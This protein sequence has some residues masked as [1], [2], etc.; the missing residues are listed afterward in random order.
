MSSYLETL[1][2]PS[3][4]V[5]LGRIVS[6]YGVNGLLK[7]YP[8]SED[9][10]IL[11]NISDCWIVSNKCRSITTGLNFY[12]HNIVSARIHG[13]FIIVRLMENLS[14]E[15]S[16]ALRGY[17]ICVS[18]SL[19]PS[20]GDDE[21]Y[22]VDLIGCFVHGYSGETQCCIGVVNNIFENGA[23]P[24]LSITPDI[25][26]LKNYKNKNKIEDILV[27]FV[28]SY[29]VNVNLEDNCIFTSWQID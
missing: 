18:R 19:F 15:D 28:K 26:F 23:H 24:I 3:D 27:P 25:N 7:I 17:T 11:L 8:Y 6:S 10:S 16:N 4:L 9:Q 29:I 12:H 2:I 21:Y 20:T 14:R 5:E 1:N 13:K 22:W